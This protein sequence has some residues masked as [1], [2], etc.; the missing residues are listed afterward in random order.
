MHQI[1]LPLELRVNGVAL[2]SVQKKPVLRVFGVLLMDAQLT[3][4]KQI[5]NL[6]TERFFFN[7][8]L[9]ELK[10][11]DAPRVMILRYYPTLSRN[12][13]KPEDYSGKNSIKV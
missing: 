12:T 4:R 8:L 10:M 1:G 11:L 9:M 2:Y 3:W 7:L 6:E 5:E 13:S